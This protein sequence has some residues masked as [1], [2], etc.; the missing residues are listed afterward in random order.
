MG[1]ITSPS[2]SNT[3]G[4][5]EG[6]R[7]K[8]RKGAGR[9]LLSFFSAKNGHTLNTSLTGLLFPIATENRDELETNI[10]T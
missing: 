6:G 9:E 5:R 3:T 7:K 1:F 4:G 10:M 8:G 2:P